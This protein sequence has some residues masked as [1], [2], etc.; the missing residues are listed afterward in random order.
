LLVLAVL[1]LPLCCA[2]AAYLHL[3]Q[4][5]V[6]VCEALQLLQLRERQLQH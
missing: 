2:V 1:L 5:C 4:L 6:A 3:L